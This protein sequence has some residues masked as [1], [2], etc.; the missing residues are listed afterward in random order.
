MLLKITRQEGVRE[1]DH[2]KVIYK[3]KVD[4]GLDKFA[5][6]YTT[7]SFYEILKIYFG[8]GN[9]TWCGNEEG[10]DYYEGVLRVKTKEKIEEQ[11]KIM[12]VELSELVEAF[13]DYLKKLPKI[14]EKEW[15]W[16]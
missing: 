2:V 9:V 14:E 4:E 11:E 16:E 13:K 5:K 3:I 8:V 12:Y 6:S 7:R 1:M 15:V 10:F